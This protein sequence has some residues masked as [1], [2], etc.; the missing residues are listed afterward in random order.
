MDSEKTPL[1]DLTQ[2]EHQELVK[3]HIV[4]LTNR[5]Y[6][7]EVALDTLLEMYI[8]DLPEDKKEAWKDIFNDK[9]KA[10]IDSINEVIS[11][12]AD[13]KIETEDIIV[14]PAMSVK[15]SASVEN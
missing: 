9:Y 5:L 4:N 13:R 3:N 11:Q 14:T 10:K 8:S 15:S 1:K 2:E 7:A 12:R 6:G